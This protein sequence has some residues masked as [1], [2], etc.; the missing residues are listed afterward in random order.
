VIAVAAALA[1][2]CLAALLLA[3]SARAAGAT[4]QAWGR[5]DTGQVGNGE[6]TPAGCLCVNA[7]TAVQA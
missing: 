5:N 4:A 2:A 3:G 1:A 6:T 7:P